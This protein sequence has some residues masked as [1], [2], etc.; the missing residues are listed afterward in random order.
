[1]C[2]TDYTSKRGR[3]DIRH[4]VDKVKE[5][6]NDLVVITG[7]EPFRQNITELC[8]L[9]DN[10]LFL[11]QV[12]TNGAIDPPAGFIEFLGWANK[13]MS[14]LCVVCSPKTSK[15]SHQMKWAVGAW[16]YVVRAGEIEPDGMPTSAL[17]MSGIPARPMNNGQIYI[18]PADEKD[19][20]Q[21]QLNMK[22]AV[23]S[24]ITHGHR[25]CLQLHKIAGLD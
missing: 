25:L 19:P 3:Q 11:V 7:G 20:E 16:K 4:I 13:N 5:L 2:D 6:K 24:C 21:N 1:M 8:R 23:E 17:G 22:A 10:E 18:Q 15:L 14:R 12:E 9:L